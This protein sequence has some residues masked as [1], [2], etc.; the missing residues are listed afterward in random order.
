MPCFFDCDAFS[1]YSVD[2]SYPPVPVCEPNERYA[3]LISGAYA[4]EGSETTAIAQYASHR[5]FTTDYPD[6]FTAYKYIAFVKM[7]HFQLLG[8][9]IM[10]LGYAPLIGSY[11]S[12]LYWNGSFPSYQYGLKEILEA[13]I[14]G[15]HAAIAHYRRLISQIDNK[16]FQALFSRII[17]DE[18]KHVEVLSGFYTKYL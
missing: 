16:G 17:L 3:A 9:L 11:E 5:Y 13:D 15:E 14:E 4:G 6:V 10:R 2:L 12:G 8:S 18:E 1:Q 7:V